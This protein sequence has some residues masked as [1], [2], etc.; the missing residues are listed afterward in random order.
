M[1]KVLVVLSLLAFL[2][3]VPSMAQDKKVRKATKSEMIKK[4]AKKDC[5]TCKDAT[6]CKD[7]E[8]MKKKETKK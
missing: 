6:T 1:K 3:A 4:D 7:K 8:A 5:G 2:V